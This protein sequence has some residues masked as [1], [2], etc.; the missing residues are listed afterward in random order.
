M[1]IQLY[2]MLSKEIWCCSLQEGRG[3]AAP[4]QGALLQAPA[5]N[6]T[7]HME[8]LVTDGLHVCTHYISSS[9]Q[10]LLFPEIIQGVIQRKCMIAGKIMP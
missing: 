1:F 10:S 5:E 6:P 9:S 3:E 7:H 2:K 4:S 8:H